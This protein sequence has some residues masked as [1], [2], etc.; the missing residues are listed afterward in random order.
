MWMRSLVLVL[1][2]DFGLS[3]FMSKERQWN[4]DDSRQH[5]NEICNRSCQNCTEP[6]KCSD[7]EYKCPDSTS[8]ENDCPSDETCVPA[9][10]Q[11]KL[12]RI[13]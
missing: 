4:E 13:C 3:G 10:C 9:G 2:V 11:C 7:L 6:Y 5:C 12:L 8:G 1:V